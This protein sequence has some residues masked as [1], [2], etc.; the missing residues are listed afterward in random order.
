MKEG[1]KLRGIDVGN[2]LRPI[3]PLT[4]ETRE[5]LKKIIGNLK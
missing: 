1:L 2:A 4:V 3:K 5:K